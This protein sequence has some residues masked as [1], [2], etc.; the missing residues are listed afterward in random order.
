M[1][2]VWLNLPVDG[3]VDFAARVEGS[4]VRSASGQTLRYLSI[5]L[6]KFRWH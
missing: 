5:N 2:F 1:N 4:F 6:G 3:L